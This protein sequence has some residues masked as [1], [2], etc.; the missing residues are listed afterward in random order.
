MTFTKFVRRAAGLVGGT[1]LAV[2]LAA[3]GTALARTNYAMVVGVTAYP[4]L[5]K[6]NW[7]IGPRNDAIFVR[8]FLTTQSHVPF[9]EANVLLLAD[10]VEGAR[11]PTLAHILSSLDELAAKVERDDF[12]YLQ[13][14]GH[15]FQQ[16]AADPSTE[17]DGLDE[18]FLPKDT[19]RWVD[20]SKGM[21]NALVDDD[22]G[23]ALEKIRGKG[24]FVWVVFDACHSGTATRAAPGDDVVERKIGPEAVGMPSEVLYE[25]AATRDL[26]GG[27]PMKPDAPVEFGDTGSGTGEKGGMVAFFAAQTNETTPEM[28]LPLGAKDATKYGLFTHTIFSQ[29]G[30]NPNVSYRQLAQGI[31]QHYVSINRKDTTPLFEG[32]LDAPVFGTEIDDVVPQWPITVSDTGVTL[33]AGAVH[34]VTPGARL[35]ILETPGATDDEAIGYL[36]VTSAQNFISRV[37]VEVPEDAKDDANEDIGQVAKTAASPLKVKSPGDI[38]ATA[39][40]RLITSNLDFTLRVARPAPS[41]NHP[42]KLALVNEQLDRLAASETAPFRIALVEPGAAAELRLAVMAKADLPDAGFDAS[43]DPVLWFLPESGALSLEDGREP[44]SIVMQSDDADAIGTTIGQYLARIYRATNLGRIGQASDFAPGEVSAEFVLKRAGSGATE[45]ITSTNMPFAQPPDRVS[46]LATNNTGTLVDLN[47][48]Y[49]GSDYSIT[50]LAKERLQPG[51]SLPGSG[52][53][54]E[55]LEFTTDS[56]GLETMVAVFTEAL[57]NTLTEDL[58]ILAQ[59]G[60]RQ[61]MRSGGPAS[62]AD[63]IRVMGNA[64]ATRA[65][66]PLGGMAKTTPRGSVQ[67]LPVRTVKP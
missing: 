32:D 61:V 3:G 4:N 65:V 57:P 33:P 9:D 16:T 6:S 38:P 53:P 54:A 66:K 41:E 2:V 39:Y 13:F 62:I 58:G 5:S 14:S 29:I 44:P 67:L 7:L 64:G 11:E 8:D 12:V 55:I 60:L 28:P 26:S 40:A 56:Y 36:K 59:D 35:A 63:L 1:A 15:G 20:R 45:T 52:V 25:G 17:T 19:G 46:L 22:I 23:K 30:A 42:E 34:G 43:P 27:T 10:D 51:A 31:L 18:I 21:P 37:T 49:I 50:H 24:A 48:L 47:V